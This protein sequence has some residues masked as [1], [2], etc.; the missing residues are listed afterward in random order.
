VSETEKIA[1]TIARQRALDE[2]SRISRSDSTVSPASYPFVGAVSI[3]ANIDRRT[4]AFDTG[5]AS[6]T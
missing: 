1:S 2:Y 6:L 3:T 4:G 5:G